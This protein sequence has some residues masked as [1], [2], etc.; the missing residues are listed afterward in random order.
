MGYIL[1]FGCFFVVVGGFVLV[2]LVG[3]VVVRFLRGFVVV[4]G[5][6]SLVGG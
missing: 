6:F 1:G 3:G 2:G 5:I 4:R